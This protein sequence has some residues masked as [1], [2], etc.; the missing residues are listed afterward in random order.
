M[1]T[2][3]KI[4]DQKRFVDS[5]ATR[6]GSSRIADFGSSTTR[7]DVSV[8]RALARLD[9]P[10]FFRIFHLLLKSVNQFD[11]PPISHLIPLLFLILHL[12]FHLL[13]LRPM[14]CTCSNSLVVITTLRPQRAIQMQAAK[15]PM[16]I[17]TSVVAFTLIL[18]LRSE[19][20]CHL[21]VTGPQ[22]GC[23]KARWQESAH[24]RMCATSRS[25]LRQP[26]V[27]LDRPSLREKQPLVPSCTAQSEMKCCQSQYCHAEIMHR[28][29]L[30]GLR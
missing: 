14:P 23:A 3:S 26:I 15:V 1:R 22:S 16:I 21:R 30:G 12:H 10:P 27:W 25:Y 24:V 28:I 9:S 7:L 18:V 8:V 13:R 5:H 2:N 19:F 4:F 29:R 20:V 6:I 17:P 11:R